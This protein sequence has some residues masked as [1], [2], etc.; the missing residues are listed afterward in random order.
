[1][2]LQRMLYPDFKLRYAI[3]AAG[4][5]T[6]LIKNLISKINHFKS[7]S[8]VGQQLRQ[9]DIGLCS[10]GQDW[11]RPPEIQA[12]VKKEEE[13][14]TGWVTQNNDNNRSQVLHRPMQNNF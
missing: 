1:M 10:H 3:L 14:N 5:R 7:I 12:K 6:I 8:G 11:L 13:I 4:K 2:S 9:Q